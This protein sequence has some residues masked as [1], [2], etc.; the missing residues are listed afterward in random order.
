M[1]IEICVHS[2]NKTG[3]NGIILLLNNTSPFN[4]EL[5]P[6][7]NKP[8]IDIRLR[9]GMATTLHAYPIGSVRT[10]PRHSSTMYMTRSYPGKL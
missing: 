4:L 1:I 6:I 9:P 5:V 3:A 7:K 10:I 8:F 2:G